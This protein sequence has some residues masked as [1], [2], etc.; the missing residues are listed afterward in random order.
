M[1][2]K[3]LARIERLSMAQAAIEAVRNAGGAG[4]L[5]QRRTSPTPTPSPPSSRRSPRAHG[6]IDV[7]IHAAGLEI[8]RGSADKELREYDLVFDVKSDGWFNLMHAIGDLPVGATVAFSSVAGRFGNLGQTDYSAANDLLCKLT[9]N[10]RR[11]R[12]NTRGIVVDWT[13]W[14]GI[15]MATRGSIPTMMAAAGID[16]LPA[17][18]GIATIRRELTAGG[19]RGELVVAGA[20]GVMTSE[21]DETGGLD[22]D[23]VDLSSSGPMVGRVTGMGIWSGLTVETTLD[24]AAQPFL[25]DH[26]IDGT[27]VLPGVMGVEAFAEVARL[28]LP[29]WHV[30][31]IED[32]DFR[33]PVKFYR[34]EPRTLTIRA[35]L[36]PAD[37]AVVARCAAHRHPHP[38]E[39]ARAGRDGA[40]H[41]QR[42]ARPRPSRRPSGRRRTLATGARPSAA[43]TCTRSTSTGP[44]TRCSTRPGA[45]APAP[46]GGSPPACPPTT[47]LPSAPRWPSP[48]SS[49]CASRPPA[50]RKWALPGRWACPPTSTASSSR[51]TPH[52]DGAP[53]RRS[54]PERQTV[55][56][57]PASSTTRGG[58]ECDSP[59][60]APSPCPPAS[61]ETLLSPIREADRSRPEPRG[62]A[63]PQLR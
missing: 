27:A 1:I 33:E 49:S 30:G 6:R 23:R 55:S 9:S 21:F 54:R 31:A 38:G 35:T 63:V 56:S 36:T 34:D 52:A 26:R 40:L 58:F 17:D 11:S 42:P 29:G 19:T 39:P 7:L 46:P 50:S 4:A 22:A 2:D 41:R 47:S 32:V 15:G 10:L 12:P 13:A 43:T 59:A 28:L 8:S 24:P 60:T 51:P 62:K 45:P 14:G 18:A 5:P 20:L 44:P 25:N 48:G 53:R 16:M 3:E 61:N 37:D 57:T